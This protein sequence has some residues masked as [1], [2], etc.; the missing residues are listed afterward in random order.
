[1]NTFSFIKRK[2]SI[3]CTKILNYSCLYSEIIKRLII[4][5]LFPFLC[6][7]NKNRDIK[8]KNLPAGFIHMISP[9][10]RFILSDTP[11]KWELSCIFVIE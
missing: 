3:Y 8:Q 10:G 7:R 2:H 4:F 1:M 9:V 5:L 6:E 11:M